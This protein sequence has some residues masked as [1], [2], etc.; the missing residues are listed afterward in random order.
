MIGAIVEVGRLAQVIGYSLAAGVGLSVVFALVVSG[1]AGALDALRERRSS[2]VAAW[3]ALTI[4]CAAVVVGA[5]VLAVVVMVA[6]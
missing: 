6:K 4:L 2:A 1:T 3:S 5:I